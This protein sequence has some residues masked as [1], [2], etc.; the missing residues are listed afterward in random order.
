M[1]K[2]A[3][4]MQASAV[5]VTAVAYLMVNTLPAVTG[6][7]ARQ[8]EFQPS[9]V[10]AFGTA[11]IGG[12]AVGA[13]LAI[14]L[15]RQL[16]PRATVT[17]GLLLL[18]AANS[19]YAAI[20]WSSAAIAWSFAVVAL[21]AVGGIGTG[22]TVSACNYV[23]SLKNR[24]RSYAASM[25]GFM[26]L[27]ALVIPL[28]PPL[29]D[30]LGWRSVFVGFALLVLPCFALSRLFPNTYEHDPAPESPRG[31]AGA[32]LVWL[33]FASVALFSVGQF[34]LWTYL[35]R[36][37]SAM[38]LAETTIASSLSVA[39]VFGFLSSAIALAFGQRILRSGLIIA[40]L[41]INIAG[42]LGTRSSSPWLYAISISGF[43]FSL[44]IYSAVLFGAILRRAGSKCF[45][46]QFTL[47]LN[48]GALGPALGG[49][50]AEQYGYGSVAWFEVALVALSGALLW[51]GFMSP[52]VLR[53]PSAETAYA[54]RSS[55]TY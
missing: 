34:A 51:F 44:P 35:E 13:F 45:A 30:H 40:C 42:A 12:A 4:M 24:E 15:M 43:Y 33:G 22:L 18:W 11:E 39:T 37:G 10:G 47:G 19:C 38:G 3:T 9:T 46:A 14:L 29:A 26:A 7:L 49:L 55:A 54:A 17:L 16:S 31:P 5:I 52:K 20:A 32:R 53:R 8:L 25:L 2:T 50:L 6:V 21:R 36:I 41:V 27:A 48:I 1:K 23:F 28:I